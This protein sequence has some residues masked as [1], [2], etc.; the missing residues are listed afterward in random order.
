MGFL[1]VMRLLSGCNGPGFNPRSVAWLLTCREKG[2]DRQTITE[3]LPANNLTV[4][5]L[6]KRPGVP[7]A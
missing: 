1:S 2:A 6:A 5:N 3:L 7:V 4:S